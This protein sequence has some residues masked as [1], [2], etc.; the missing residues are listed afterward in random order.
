LEARIVDQ[1]LH[2]RLER[3]GSDAPFPPL[4]GVSDEDALVY[5]PPSLARFGK[6]TNYRVEGRIAQDRVRAVRTLAHD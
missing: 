5:L 2:A 3:E 4:I 1:S 6:A